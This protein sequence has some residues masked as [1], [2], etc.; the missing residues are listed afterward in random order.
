MTKHW[1]ESSGT[2]FYCSG[3][4]GSSWVLCY[5]HRVQWISQGGLFFPEP[6]CYLSDFLIRLD[7]WLHCRGFGPCSAS[8]WRAA[9]W[10]CLRLWFEEAWQVTLVYVWLLF[11][12]RSRPPISRWNTFL[13]YIQRFVLDILLSEP[14]CAIQLWSVVDCRESV[15]HKE[16]SYLRN[17]TQSGNSL[18]FKEH[19][20]RCEERCGWK[21][22]YLLKYKEGEF[23]LVVFIYTYTAHMYGQLK[24]G[25]IFN[26][27]RWRT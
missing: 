21:S 3:S 13:F 24:T 7:S 23:G 22:I 6:S 18:D 2:I 27:W 17:I 26:P 14:G 9:L 25:A 8:R 4:G 20:K 5:C 12:S 16:P 19:L 15:W 1:R 11:T 10:R